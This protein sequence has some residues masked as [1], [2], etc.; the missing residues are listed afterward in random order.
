[1]CFIRFLSNVRNIFEQR[2]REKRIHDE[3][4]DTHEMHTDECSSPRIWERMSEVRPERKERRE[5]NNKK[6]D[7]S[8][9]G[10]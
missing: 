3:T 1:M 9:P 8:L 5:S 7:H 4:H 6:F 10:G 2:S